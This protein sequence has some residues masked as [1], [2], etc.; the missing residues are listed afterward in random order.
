MDLE[1]L[2]KLRKRLAEIRVSAGGTAGRDAAKAEIDFEVGL[3]LVEALAQLSV[4]IDQSKTI[5]GTRAQEL[6]GELKSL[7]ESTA[8][9]ADSAAE[10]TR[11]LVAW[12]KGYAIA[13]FLLVIAMIGQLAL[14]WFRR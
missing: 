6:A 13:S 14:M 11:S 7:K 12:T 3:A 5:L 1:E 4:D 8:Q 9:A 2:R 10:Q